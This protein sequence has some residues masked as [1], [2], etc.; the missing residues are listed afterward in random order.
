MRRL[1][2]EGRGPRKTLRM[3]C[4]TWRSVKF[5]LIPKIDERWGPDECEPHGR[6][7]RHSHQ[8]EICTIL[9][10]LCLQA[11]SYRN[12]RLAT[13]VSATCNDR[14][15]SRMWASTDSKSLNWLLP[16]TVN[17][18]CRLSKWGCCMCYATLPRMAT[19]LGNSPRPKLSFVFD[20]GS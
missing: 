20:F 16:S 10:S 19:F 8:H 14:S 1:V 13:N 4:E 5:R 7:D 2:V 6:S 11:L 9:L 18:Q 17:I 3:P 12:I 15:A